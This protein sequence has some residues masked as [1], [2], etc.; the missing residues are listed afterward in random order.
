M[1]RD[2][3][4]YTSWRCNK[5]GNIEYYLYVPDIPDH[6]KAY[7]KLRGHFWSQFF[8]EDNWV[9]VAWFLNNIPHD[10]ENVEEKDDDY[11]EDYEKLKE[12]L[13]W[14]DEQPCDFTIGWY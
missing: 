14:C 3:K 8:Q 5:E 12:L 9:N 6:L 11:K 1:F 2:G 7:A 10:W 4:P 13:F